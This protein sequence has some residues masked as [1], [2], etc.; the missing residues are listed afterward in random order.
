MTTNNAGS[1]AQ[2]STAAS[3]EIKYPTNCT[4]LNARKKH[5][6]KTLHDHSH[7]LFADYVQQNNRRTKNNIIFYTGCFKAWK[8]ILCKHYQHVLKEGIGRGGRLTICEDE[9]LA[10]D[11]PVLKITYYTKGTVLLQ[12][13][14]DNLNDF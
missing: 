5:K 3:L 13:T 14:E 6:E 11:N 7:T 4:S 12:G 10:T 2:H 1:S 8:I 9:N